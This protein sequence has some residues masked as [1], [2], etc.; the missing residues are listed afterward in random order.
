MFIVGE[1][2][3]KDIISLNKKAFKQLKNTKTKDFIIIPKAGHLFDEEPDIIEKVA[4]IS[5]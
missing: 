1:K 4:E 3:D 5:I 2:D